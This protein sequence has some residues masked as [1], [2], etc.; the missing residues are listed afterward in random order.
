MILKKY[1][2]LL[3]LIATNAVGQ[4]PVFQVYSYGSLFTATDSSA[5][6]TE[7]KGSVYLNNNFLPVQIS[8]FSGKIPPMRYNA[9]KDEME[10]QVDDK[11]Y[12]MVKIDSCEVLLDN[13]RYKYLQYQEV[14]A[15]EKRYLLVLH[16]E[17][18]GKFSLYK[19]E[20]MNLITEVKPKSGYDE[21]RP[22]NYQLE[23]VK[24]YLS[25]QNKTIAMPRKENDVLALFQEKADRIKVFI[26]EKEISLRDE[27]DIIELV[28]FLNTLK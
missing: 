16:T 27:K 14:E 3:L 5:K 19:K 4:S 9:L 18:K 15:I 25:L 2:Y 10:Y 11:L 28:K 17:D 1:Y 22:A 23:A 21:G 12:Y 8:C 6:E 26:K 20:K 13:K 7:I 24:Y